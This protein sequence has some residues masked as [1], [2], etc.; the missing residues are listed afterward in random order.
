MK[1]RAM[2]TKPCSCNSIIGPLREDGLLPGHVCASTAEITCRQWV[3]S[4]NLSPQPSGE[5]TSILI[6][7][8]DRIAE[9]RIRANPDRSE[10]VIQEGFGYRDEIADAK[11]Q[12]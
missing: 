3:T 1:A 8:D 11:D 4:T 10:N 12:A 7:I 5:W 2:R 6:P 9:C